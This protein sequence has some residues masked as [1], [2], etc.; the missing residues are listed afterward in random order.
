MITRGYTFEPPNHARTISLPNIL[1]SL[2]D[3]NQAKWDYDFA[4]EE[5]QKR[6]K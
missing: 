1:A 3:K 5:Q 6:L 4:V 2:S